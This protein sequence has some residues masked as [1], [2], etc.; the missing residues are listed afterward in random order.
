MAMTPGTVGS[1]LKGPV[2]GRGGCMS[3]CSMFQMVSADG[4][5][6]AGVGSSGQDQVALPLVVTSRGR[7]FRRGG[8][9]GRWRKSQLIGADR[10][11]DAG[12]GGSGQE[13]GALLLI[14]P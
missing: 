6:D 14:V 5:G 2:Y 12:V 7:P 9:R 3:R 11:G 10:G 4:S 13:K 8:C 1:C